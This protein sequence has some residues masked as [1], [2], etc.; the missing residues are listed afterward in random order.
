M[1]S[2]TEDLSLRWQSRVTK[3]PSSPEF[4]FSWMPGPTRVNP[5]ILVDR[6]AAFGQRGTDSNPMIV[7]RIDIS[8]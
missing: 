6:A 5:P 1:W 7:V 3:A 2:R 8:V 4:K